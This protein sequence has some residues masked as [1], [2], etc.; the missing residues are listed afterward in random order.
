MGETLKLR[1]YADTLQNEFHEI[2]S[3]FLGWTV[4]PD[5]TGK[6]YGNY[7]TFTY[8]G[9]VTTLYAQWSG[10]EL[11]GSSTAAI[12]NVKYFSGT[13]MLYDEGNMNRHSSPY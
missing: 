12:Y 11:I 3:C 8:D 7:D 10:E 6:S 1:F 13:D 9:T 2:L 5:G 4:N